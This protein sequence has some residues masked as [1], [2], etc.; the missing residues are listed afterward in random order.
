MFARRSTRMFLWLLAGLVCFSSVARAQ[1]GQAEVLTL[2]QAV[3]LAL[4][5]NRQIKSAA[6]EVEKYSDKLAALRTKR[7]PE[8]K[9]NTLASQLLT[10]MSYTFEKGAFGEYPGI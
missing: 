1:G 6:I 5:Q 4:S 3:E 2:E 9:F 7:L 10:P 8:F